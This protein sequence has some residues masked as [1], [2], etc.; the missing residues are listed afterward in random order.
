MNLVH[1]FIVAESA[2]IIIWSEQQHTSFTLQHL[3]F[4]ILLPLR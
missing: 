1:I 4:V 3:I 2:G